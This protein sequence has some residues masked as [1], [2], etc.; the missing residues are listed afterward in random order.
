MSGLRQRPLKGRIPSLG[1]LAESDTGRAAGLAAAVIV[2]N[3]MALLFTVV[4]ARALGAAGYGS[5]AALLSAFI[6]LMVPGSALQ[7]ATA[8]EISH[9]VARGDSDPGRGVRRWL[10]RLLVATVVVAIVAVPLRSV[11]AAV[12]NV[13]QVWAAA[14]VPVTSMLWMIACVERGALQGLQ[15]YRHVGLSLVG[16]ATARVALA[17]GL[18]GVGLGVTGAFL[19][20]G[21]AL[22]VVAG[23]LLIPL[24]RRL[25]PRAAT[26]DRRLRDLLAGS[27]VPVIGLTLLFALQEVHVIVVKHE[28]SAS[29]AGAYAVAGVAGKAIIWVAIGLGM[30]LLP[31]AT[32]RSQ[33]GEDATPILRQTLGLIA[34]ASVPMVLVYAVAAEPVL[35]LAFGEKLTG[36]T[37]ALPWLGLAMAFLACSYLC[38]QYLL[39]LGRVNF[40]WILGLAALAEVGVLIGIG[41]NLTNVARGLCALQAVCAAAVLFVALRDKPAPEHAYVNLQGEVSSV[42]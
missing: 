36:G 37:G 21:L 25:P 14:A 2:T 41:S 18:V 31:E 40:V 8:R 11:L 9:A 35:R 34:A 4:F 33:T 29:A 30:Y 6:I 10:V 19:A 20:S 39:A 3:L 1:A 42:G 7:V 16:E 28:A 32:R 15:C 12:I 24:G 13:D 26:G 17:L 22:V 27:V 23:V 38:V 5:L